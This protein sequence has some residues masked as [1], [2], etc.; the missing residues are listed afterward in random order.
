MNNE[1]A[2]AHKQVASPANPQTCPQRM[3]KNMRW[4]IG[5]LRTMMHSSK[6]NNNN[7]NPDS[8]KDEIIESNIKKTVKMSDPTTFTASLTPLSIDSIQHRQNEESTVAA[9]KVAGNE[10]DE[11]FPTGLAVTPL[12]LYSDQSYDKVFDEFNN[13]ILLPASVSYEVGVMANFIGRTLMLI[14]R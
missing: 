4:I 8:G 2:T 14:L 13:I 10:G 9:Q 11:G 1:K 5:K 6:N 12:P 3:R 7:I